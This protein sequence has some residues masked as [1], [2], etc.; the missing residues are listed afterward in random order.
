L[1][2]F[3]ID[4]TPLFNGIDQVLCHYRQAKGVKSGVN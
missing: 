2:E 4:L 1:E 3:E